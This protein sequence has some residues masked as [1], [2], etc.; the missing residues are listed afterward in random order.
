MKQSHIE[1]KNGT[2]CLAI[3]GELLPACAYMTYFDERNDYAEFAK[4]GF[5][6]YSVSVSFA[7]QPIN[8]SSGFMPYVGGVFDCKGKADFSAVDEAVDEILRH[9]PDAYIFPRIYV[10]MP[11]WWIDENPQETIRVPL[12]CQREAIY[13]TVFAEDASVMLREMIAHFRSFH[14]AD[15]IFGYQ[16]SG[17]NTQEWFHL[18]LNG[19]YDPVALPYFNAWLQT[20]RPELYPAATL[21]PLDE[22]ESKDALTDPYLV[23]YQRFASESVA[24]TVKTLC[25][26]AKEAASHEQIVGVFSGYSAEVSNT[27]WGTHALEQVIDSPDIDFISSPNS[28][29]DARALGIDWADML[30]VDSVKLRGKVCLLECDV[31]TYLT[32]SPGESREGSDP[33]HYYTHAVWAG[34][35]TR[36]LSVA[37]VRKCLA[38]QLTHKHGLWWFDMFGHWYDDE[39]LM[40]EMARSLALYTAATN[41]AVSEFAAEVAVFLDETS[42]AMLGRR[43]PTYPTGFW[44]RKAL[45]LAGAPYDFYLMT[46][47]DKIDFTVKGYKAAVF[48]TLGSPENDARA[49]A[50]LAKHGIPLMAVTAEEPQITVEALTAFYRACG[51]FTYCDTPDVVY[52]G[53]GC[54]AL[55][56][57][58]AGEKTVRLPRKVWCTDLDT[59]VCAYTDILRFTCKQYETKLF[60]MKD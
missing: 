20:H 35:P 9:C 26:V 31:R 59:N 18:D 21:P 37:A 7:S 56:A 45:G 8:S 24:D 17:G 36:E 40:D 23:A 15:H 38:H 50:A 27:M 60:A 44:G 46:D 52:V 41:D 54:A 30:P 32:K 4:R 3:G 25:R 58:E 1:L 39:A 6:V 34:P 51:V 16:I 13:S 2:P 53:N 5:R 11:Q 33:H 29:M 49:R 10:C 43:H 47:A 48:V 12:G 22:L 57:A 55:H 19:S 42:Y 28:Y 14:A